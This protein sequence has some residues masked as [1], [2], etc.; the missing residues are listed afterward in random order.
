MQFIIM[1]HD[2]P[3]SLDKRLAVRQQH[4]DTCMGMKKDGTMTYGVALIDEKGDMCGSMIVL[5]VAD[6][7]AVD[8]YL[9]DEP[10]VKGGVWGKIEVIPCKIGPSFAVPKAA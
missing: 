10:Y 7:A 3:N 1:A 2:H 9:K 8:A 5:D 4:I 6:R